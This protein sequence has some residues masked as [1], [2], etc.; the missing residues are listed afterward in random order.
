MYVLARKLTKYNAFNIE[1]NTQHNA[2]CY[3]IILQILRYFINISITIAI[4]II[5][6]KYIINSIKTYLLY[7][8]T[9][10]LL[11][12]NVLHII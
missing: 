11:L 10:H 5:T 9:T 6:V 1:K 7:A 4:N 12:H 8:V 2:I 3:A